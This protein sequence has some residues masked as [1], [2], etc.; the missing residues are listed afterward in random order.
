M[1]GKVYLKNGK[2]KNILFREATWRNM[3]ATR[4][5]IFLA[6]FVMLVHALELSIEVV[7]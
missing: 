2:E 3:N 6:Y 5:G 4:R 7:G 1:D